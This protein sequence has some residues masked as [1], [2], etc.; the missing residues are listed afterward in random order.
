MYIYFICGYSLMFSKLMGTY[1][2]K[3]VLGCGMCVIFAVSLEV[4]NDI[5]Q[6]L[7]SKPRLVSGVLSRSL[8]HRTSG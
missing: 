3:Y 7:M 4:L 8:F 2:Y 1:L 5:V 6:H